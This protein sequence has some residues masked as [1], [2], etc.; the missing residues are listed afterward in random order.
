[1]KYFSISD[2]GK[3]RKNN[4]DNYINY[5]NDVFS[6]FIVADGIGG[7]NAG[8]I[9][10]KMAVDIVSDYIINNFDINKIFEIIN[11]SIKYANREIYLKSTSD[12]E[13]NGMGTT[14]VLC[15]VYNK[16]MYF[17]NVGDSRIYL[18]R[19]NIFKQ[20]T[21]DHSYVQELLDSGAI[22]EEESKFYPRNQITSA[23]GTSLTYKIDID[24]I[25][26]KNNDYIMLN[27]DG[28]T[29][30]I[31]DEDIHNVIKNEYEVDETV[32]ILK[33]MANSTGG[34]D[35]ITITLI[36]FEE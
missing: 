28:L 18:Y 32:E 36:K 6:L 5:I 17:A 4:E 8:E 35:N 1:M 33:Y 3:V 21:K 16:E 14:I 2:I 7:H 11:E 31:E 10:S 15:L 29:D 23:L 20:I 19:K 30:L 22:T 12:L 25:K 27:T 9:A 26:L 13:N 24:K 34:Y